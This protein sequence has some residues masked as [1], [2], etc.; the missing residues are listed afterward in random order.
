LRLFDRDEDISNEV[1][2]RALQ[3]SGCVAQEAGLQGAEKWLAAQEEESCCK[4]VDRGCRGALD[5][6]HRYRTFDL[7]CKD[8]V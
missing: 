8:D 3:M 5:A 7:C 2:E 1:S 4:A 6:A